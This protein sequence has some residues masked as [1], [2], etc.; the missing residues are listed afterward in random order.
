M[1]KKTTSVIEENT[2]SSSGSVL[3]NRIAIVILAAAL[4][5]AVAVAGY[6]YY[7]YKHIP[8][9]T[10]Q[11]DVAK[12]VAEVGALLELPQ[13]ETP[14]LA[15][16]TDKEKLA[17]Q[18]FFQKAENGDKVLIYSASGRAILYRP[19]TKKIVDM[20]TVNVNQPTADNQQLPATEKPAETQP[21]QVAETPVAAKVALY[22]G[23]V[24]VGVTN[25]LEDEIKA[26]FPDVT[27]VAKEK[28]AKNDYQ[29]NLV[30][31][32][33]GT[34]TELAQKLAENIGG[35]VGALPANETKPAADILVVVGNKQ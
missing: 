5:S 23:S 8:Q 25:I 21:S 3:W 18:P 15:T 34:H 29:G 31:D 20:T 12:A 17:E 6:F 30:I 19:S 14:T 16:V 28:A 4:F 9:T 24:K 22:N 10:T 33:S 26:A 35:T 11:D 13:E 32:L 7:Q 2:K 1:P 27:I